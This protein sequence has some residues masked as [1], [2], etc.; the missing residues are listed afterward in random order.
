MLNYAEHLLNLASAV[1]RR[2]Q[3]SA[4]GSL[5]GIPVDIASSAVGIK[6][7]SL[8]AGVKKYKSMIKK[9]KK[10]H[11]KI[12]LLAKIKLNIIEVF[13]SQALIDSN[14][15]HNKF[16]LINHVLQEYNEMKEEIKNP[17]NTKLNFIVLNV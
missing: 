3:I 17:N 2:V 8:T 13:I 4:L 14:I 5:V 15:N 12:V 11:D 9:K 6:I 16:V 7:C 10:K 1:T